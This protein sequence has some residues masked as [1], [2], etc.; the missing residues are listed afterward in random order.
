MTAKKNAPQVEEQ[1]RTFKVGEEMIAQTNTVVTSYKYRL[2]GQTPLLMH[3]D[4]VD[5]QDRL[6]AWRKAPENK[7]VS[8]AGDDRSP[9]W[10][11][12]TYCYSDQ[13]HLAIPADNIMA[14]L[15]YAGSSI[16]LKKQ[17]T[18]KSV[19]QSGIVIRDF[20]SP[21]YVG[22]GY[23]ERGELVN[24]RQ[25]TAASIDRI[26][27]TFSQHAEAA[28]ALGFKL[29][30][31]RAPIGRAKHVRVRPRF[32]FWEVRGIV[33]VVAKEI[34]D[35]VMLQL[36]EIA[37]NYAGLCD[38]RPASPQSPGPFG[39]FAARLQKLKL[40]AGEAAA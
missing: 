36:F 29:F 18:F 11:W 21:L 5:Q 1:S 25:I 38:W 26:D 17:K 33:D 4:D 24:A 15:R 30:V 34:T 39:R 19:T 28:K 35:N 8:K 7:N 14:A 12:K 3:A 32:D 27:G 9:A 6:D 40:T 22:D 31:K 10:T 2:L 20:F 23:D 13:E 16:T 37:G